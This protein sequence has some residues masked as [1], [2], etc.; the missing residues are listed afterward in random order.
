MGDI[1]EGSKT[2]AEGV[3]TIVR[4]RLRHIMGDQPST[5]DL[6]HL[7]AIR[8]VSW[9]TYTWAG[10][11]G[12]FKSILGVKLQSGLKPLVEPT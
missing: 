8:L 6:N 1:K 11:V 2:Q 5:V 3:G 12:W 4:S 7:R 10:P 9:Q